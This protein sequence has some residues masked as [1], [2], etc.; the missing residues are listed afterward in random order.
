VSCKSG[1]K[2][3]EKNQDAV[4][5]VSGMKKNNLIR[6]SV[7]FALCGL[8]FYVFSRIGIDQHHDGVMLFPA[9]KVARGAVVFRDV[10][11][12]Y[13]LFVP[14]MQGAAVA[15]FG[16]E[17][18]VI[19]ILTVLFYAGT[20]VV[21]DC[22]WRRFLPRGLSWLVPVMFCLFASCT[23]V[24]FHSWNSVYALF[25]MM[26][27]GYFAIRHLES[28]ESSLKWLVFAGISAGL[29]WGC[30]TPCGIVTVFALILVFCGLNFFTGKAKK[31]IRQEILALAVGIL[32]V[33]VLG[34]G[35]ILLTGAWDDFVRQ[36]VGFVSGFVYERGDNGN[37]KYLSES[38]FPFYQEEFWFAHTFFAILPLAAM[39]I[40]YFSCRRGFLAGAMREEL[41]LAMLLILALGSWH[42]Y[43]P[44]P[45]VRHLYWGGAPMFG[46]YLLAISKLYQMKSVKTYVL[47]GILILI[48]LL[49]AAPRIYGICRRV[50]FSR[51]SVS[52][53]P[54]IRG[55]RLNGYE[56]K[57]SEFVR[58]TGELP[59][60]IRRRGVLNWSE[61]SLLTLLTD[62][63]DIKDVQ[64]YRFETSQ[65][66]GYDYRMLEYIL[67]KRPVVLTDHPV[68]IPGYKVFSYTDFASKNYMLLIPVQ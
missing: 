37:W 36:S 35:Y 28:P 20:A 50:E 3:V 27:T 21:M 23:M 4:S 2:T 47:I 68:K 61:D 54:G 62:Q 9:V 52:E 57:V 12:Q 63:C 19:R 6:G 25:F 11:C 45:C 26:L 29:T 14:L 22:C 24:T 44:V 56:S 49:G 13:G 34:L 67:E 59:E 17:L 18:M 1:N 43:Y 39:V 64:F 41:P 42:Q 15:L 10:F 46:A 40:L 66:P 51:R 38:L 31:L 55:I 53:V 60:N 48:A 30:R 5:A 33:A 16:A 8:F 65:Y 58:Q 32:S 7:I